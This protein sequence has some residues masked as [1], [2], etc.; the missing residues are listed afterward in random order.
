MTNTS[1]PESFFESVLE[2]LLSFGYT[3]KETDGVELGFVIQK[4]EN[5]V[6]NS[7]NTN[8]VPEGLFNAAVDAVCG[9]FLFTKKQTGRLEL[10]DLD[11]TGAVTSIKEGDTSVNFGS[12]TSEDEKL[13]LFLNI[14]MHSMDGDLVCYRR[15]Q[16]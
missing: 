2:R 15:M 14:L 4:L 10:N 6:K 16:W 13:T 7:C 5:H 9:E 12:G 3:L 11:L 8:S 1:L